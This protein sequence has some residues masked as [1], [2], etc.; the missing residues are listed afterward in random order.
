MTFPCCNFTGRSA[1]SFCQLKLQGLERKSLSICSGK[2]NSWLLRNLLLVCR[3]HFL[4]LNF[5][6]LAKNEMHLISYK[7]IFLEQN[8]KNE[9]FATKRRWNKTSFSIKMVHFQ[10]L[11]C[12]Q[13]LGTDFNSK[14]FIF[15]AKTFFLSFW[16]YQNFEEK[17]FYFLRETKKFS[18]LKKKSSDIDSNI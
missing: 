1:D 16:R 2:E 18:F 5:I 8:P 7:E 15:L 11:C 17:K 9:Y 10:E 6:L 4:N 3:F 14:L 13:S 12:F